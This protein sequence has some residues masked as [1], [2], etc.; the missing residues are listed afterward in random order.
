MLPNETLLVSCIEGRDFLMKLTRRITKAVEHKIKTYQCELIKRNPRRQRKPPE[1]WM[2]FLEFS[3][4]HL[5]R[6]YK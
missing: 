4:A 3:E 1:T 2:N 6:L 5:E